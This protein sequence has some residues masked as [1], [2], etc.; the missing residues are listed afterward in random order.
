MA[1]NIDVHTEGCWGLASDTHQM[2]ASALFQPE[3]LIRIGQT[4]D[5]LLHAYLG[6]PL[7][8]E[9]NHAQIVR[10]GDLVNEYQHGA[11]HRL[12]RHT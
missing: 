3:M 2:P 5:T 11:C 9:C 8:K 4:V 7:L 1:A 12:R 6:I 10:E